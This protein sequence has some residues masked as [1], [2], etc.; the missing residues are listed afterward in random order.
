MIETERTTP[1]SYEL[2]ALFARMRDAGCTHVIM[3]VSSHSLVLDRV[4]GISFAVGAFTNLTQDH[5]D[6]HKTMEEYRKAKALLFSISKKGV[7]N[8]DD[9]AA[10]KMLA[11]A[12]C[13]CMTFSCGKPEA[14]LEAT[15]LQLH[16]DGVGLM[17]NHGGVYLGDRRLDELMAELSRIKEAV[18]VDETLLVIDATTGQ[19][20]LQQA[21]EFSEVA[22]VSGIVLTKLDG[23]AKGGIAVAIM[24]EL[25]LPVLYIG[26]GEGIEDLQAFDANAFVDAIF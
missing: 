9:A 1:E 6:F 8:L 25:K 16:A 24:D 18:P 15:D 4:H 11:D 12:K 22:D 3:E 2:H 13:P 14:D 19:N 20:G 26:V 7:I 17:T 21:R 5:L 10:E 23:T